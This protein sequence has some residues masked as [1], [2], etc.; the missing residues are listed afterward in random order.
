M[1]QAQEV[2]V[3]IT[4]E[5]KNFNRI[6]IASIHPGKIIFSVGLGIRTRPV[7]ETPIL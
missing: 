5:S 4:L 1:P 7:T 2:I 3:D 6:Y